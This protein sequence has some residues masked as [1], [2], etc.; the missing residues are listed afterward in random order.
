MKEPNL[1][2][3]RSRDGETGIETQH[4]W[5]TSEALSIVPLLQTP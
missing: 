5:V 3:A 1:A 4:K 2:S